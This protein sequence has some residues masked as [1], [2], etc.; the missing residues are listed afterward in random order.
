MIFTKEAELDAAIE[1]QTQ[2]WADAA[3]GNLPLGGQ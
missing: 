2:T 1:H 3:Q